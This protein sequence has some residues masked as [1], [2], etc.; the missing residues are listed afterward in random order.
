MY[1]VLVVLIIFLIGALIVAWYRIEFL[2]DEVGD[3][4]ARCVALMTAFTA[5]EFAARVLENEARR[6]DTAEGRA[7]CKMMIAQFG[8]SSERSI[9]A[10]WLLYRADVIRSTRREKHS[11]EEAD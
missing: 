6:Y 7:E 11:A 8:P 10:R 5:D 4:H 1:G 3:D 9:P 2:T